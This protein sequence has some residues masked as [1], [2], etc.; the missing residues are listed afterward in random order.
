MSLFLRE[1]EWGEGERAGKQKRKCVKMAKIG[2][3]R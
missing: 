2:E 1:K 3:F